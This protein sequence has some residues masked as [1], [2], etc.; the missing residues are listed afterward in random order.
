M[1]KLPN[2]KIKRIYIYIYIFIF[3]NSFLS[4]LFHSPL[5]NQ[6]FFLG[7][8]FSKRLCQLDHFCYFVK[9]LLTSD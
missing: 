7:K 9:I 4:I 1:L 5:P 8:M 2:E 3:L 6:R